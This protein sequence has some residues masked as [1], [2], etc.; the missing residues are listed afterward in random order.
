MQS[1]VDKMSNYRKNAKP[2][3]DRVSEFFSRNTITWEDIYQTDT[4]EA[5][6]F[7]RYV[8]RKRKEAVLNIFQQHAAN[9]SL[10]ILD[11]GCGPGVFLAHLA[12]QGH[13]VL[14]IDRAEEM[15]REAKK[16]I[17]SGYAVEALCI[18]A[19][20]EELPLAN[21]SIDITLCL[22]VLPYL[23]DDRRSLTEIS[24]VLRKDGIVIAV[25]PNMLRINVL[26]DPFYY[27]CRVWQY[28]WHGMHRKMQGDC[29]AA[30]QE[31]IGRNRT[32]EIRR[33]LV[34]HLSTLFEQHGLEMFSARGIDFGPLTFWRREFLPVR[35]S[36]RLND[37]LN[38]LS[39]KK[40]LSFMNA[41]A[42][43]WVICL[44][45]F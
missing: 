2:H 39:Q 6:K 19:D 44:K 42:G 8:M 34:W 13:L 41:F 38:R 18:R 3:K 22:G 28:F 9:R 40:G 21:D 43:Q 29:Y 45:K 35:L 27:L 12:K 32:F 15:L 17:N 33:Y 7:D 36:M 31:D 25:L 16:K 11:I 20:I 1:N 24:R 5:W 37:T 30:D 23:G 4:S 26:L 10:R 14:G